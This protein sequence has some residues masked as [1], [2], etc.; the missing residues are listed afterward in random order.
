MIIGIDMGHPLRGGGTGA[1][2]IR[3]ETD[4]NRQVGK[5]V[6]SKL[7]AAGHTVI[8]CTTDYAVTQAQGLQDRINLAN[9]QHLDL[10]VSIHFNC[11][12]GH[13]TEVFTWRG[14]GF[15]EAKEVLNNIC[16]LGYRNRGI[17][18]GS[19]LYVIRHSKV[20]AMLIECSFIDSKEDMNRYNAEDLANAIVKGIIGK[21]MNGQV[22]IL[23]KSSKK[24]KVNYCLEFQKWF[25][26]ITQTGAPLKTDG[27]YGKNTKK[28]YE[29]ME[30]L[31][32]G[33][34]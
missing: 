18:D 2:G 19:N 31:I 7:Q 8:N 21:Y 32:R 13:G 25:N 5:K 15:K 12:G 17:K 23:R 10:F 9:A 20:K 6:I 29:A 28:A 1:A 16:A 33:E 34:Y 24:Y 30:K 4:C 26:E 14:K 22:T 27:L 11:G 3:K